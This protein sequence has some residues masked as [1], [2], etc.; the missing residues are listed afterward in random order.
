MIQSAST[1][2]QRTIVGTVADI[3]DKAHAAGIGMPAL[4]IVG[5]VVRL[6]DQLRWFDTKPLFGKRV[7][8]TRA[9]DQS[10]SLAQALR[11]RGAQAIEGEERSVEGEA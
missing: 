9:A 10:D 1:P 11:E 3:A 4:T 5:E 2:F 6:R 8:V 7:L